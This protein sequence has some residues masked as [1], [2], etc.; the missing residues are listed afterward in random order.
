MIFPQRS[1]TL[2]TTSTLLVQSSPAANV[3]FQ[4]AGSALAIVQQPAL[5]TSST[6]VQL[7]AKLQLQLWFPV[8]QPCCS[9]S[10]SLFVLCVLPLLLLLF[11]VLVFCFERDPSSSP[12]TTTCPA[13]GSHLIVST[14]TRFRVLL[15]FDIL[16]FVIMKSIFT[17]HRSRNDPVVATTILR[18]CFFAHFCFC[19]KVLTSFVV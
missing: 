14:W 15:T 16:C 10:V 5:A 7:A 13:G 1:K 8:C 11:F 6:I 4:P 2:L 19:S 3:I 18:I 17:V 9:T 12:T